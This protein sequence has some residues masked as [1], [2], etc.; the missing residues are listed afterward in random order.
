MKRHSTV[1]IITNS[2]SEAFVF[3]SP[4][5]EAAIKALVHVINPTLEVLVL[6]NEKFD[7]FIA[8]GIAGNFD[9]YDIERAITV[10]EECDKE[11]LWQA[12][13]YSYYDIPFPYKVILRDKELNEIDITELLLKC[14]QPRVCGNEW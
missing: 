9:N 3:V 8:D 7:A 5:D 13:K 1:D 4:Q 11:G 12:F 2:S 6:E 14:S 10:L